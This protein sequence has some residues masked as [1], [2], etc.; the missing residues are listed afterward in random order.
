MKR[1]RSEIDDLI[2]RF[3]TNSKVQE[4]CC[5]ICKRAPELLRLLLVESRNETYGK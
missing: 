3:H 5:V 1:E 2:S 4:L